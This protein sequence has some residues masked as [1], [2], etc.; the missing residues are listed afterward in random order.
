MHAQPVIAPLPLLAIL[1]ATLAGCAA[2]SS[3][4]EG[5][6]ADPYAVVA[7]ESG[8][9]SIEARTSP[10]QPPERGLVD[11]ELR[12]EDAAGEPAAG[13]L[14]DVEP[15]MPDMGHGTSTHP[16]VKEMDGGRYVA[17]D[18]GL[19]MPGRWELRATIGGNPND[20]AIISFQIP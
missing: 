12:V 3:G 14:V 13:V 11:V 4:A 17:S 6:P 7:T 18:L 15:W 8:A 20:R 1:I 19:F 16:A 9:F 5:F 10:I 2:D